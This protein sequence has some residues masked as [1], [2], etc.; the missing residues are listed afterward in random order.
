MMKVSAY[1]ALGWGAIAMF[2]SGW[3]CLKIFSLEENVLLRLANIH[4]SY[5]RSILDR[6]F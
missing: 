6:N 1:Y 4:K 2:V 5:K 3:L